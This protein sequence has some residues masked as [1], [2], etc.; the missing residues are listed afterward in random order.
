VSDFTYGQVRRLASVLG[1]PT[2]ELATAIFRRGADGLE[3]MIDRHFEAVATEARLGDA[4]EE[5]LGLSAG[6]S[7]TS[8]RRAYAEAASLEDAWL[9][10]CRVR[11]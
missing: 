10:R 1:V 5:R 3:T 6:P 8:V 4:W 7:S 11:D 9:A 2:A